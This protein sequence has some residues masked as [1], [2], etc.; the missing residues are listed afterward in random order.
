M[1]GCRVFFTSQY[2]GGWVINNVTT[3]D[4]WVD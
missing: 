1:A 4:K 2:I 3:R